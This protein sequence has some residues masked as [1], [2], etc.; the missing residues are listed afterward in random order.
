MDTRY[1]PS[2]LSVVILTYNKP[3]R[4]PSLLSLLPQGLEVV[5]ADDGTLPSLSEL[6]PPRVRLYTHVHDGNRASTCRN[7]GAKLT[8][9]K[10][11]LFL[12][13]D[14]TPH[15]LCLAAHSLALEMY[16]MSLGLLPREKW[17]PST[18]DRTTFYIHED[19]A[20][21]NWCWSGNLAIRRDV[22][23]G[24]EGFDADTFNGTADSPGHGFEDI[25]FGRRCFINKRS[26]CLNRFALAHHPS[27]HTSEN[28]SEAVLRNERKYREKWGE[29]AG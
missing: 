20:L 24:L 4:L 26:M 22:F 5:V 2:D 27:A 21:W 28:P 17:R 1:V 14:V 18:D 11:I 6:L 8:T 9:R 25:D 10:K 29:V 15:G 3:Q 13:D 23:F 19:Q 16:D 12:D 7:E